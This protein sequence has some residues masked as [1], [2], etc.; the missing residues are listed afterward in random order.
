MAQ[1]CIRA[2]LL[3]CNTEFDLFGAIELKD[4]CGKWREG[5]AGTIFMLIHTLLEP[6]ADPEDG[7]I[8]ACVGRNWG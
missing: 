7:L 3:V 5:A 2:H 6:V 4:P 1:A 8:G